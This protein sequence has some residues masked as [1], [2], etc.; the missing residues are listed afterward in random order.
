M[1]ITIVS[2]ILVHGMNSINIFWMNKWLHQKN[3]KFIK[4][5]AGGLRNNCLKF[6][7][8]FFNWLTN[9]VST[10][11]AGVLERSCRAHGCVCR[12]Y[13]TGILPEKMKARIPLQNSFSS[14]LPVSRLV[15]LLCCNTG[16]VFKGMETDPCWRISGHRCTFL[17]SFLAFTVLPPTT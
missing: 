9:Y 14:I 3:P 1:A 17:F 10:F 7:I 6:G 11:G 5:T 16:S 12:V 13:V 2:P 15:H 8:F 4:E